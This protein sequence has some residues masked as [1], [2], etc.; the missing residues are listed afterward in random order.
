MGPRRLE[1][2]RALIGVRVEASPPAVGALVPPR[3]TGARLRL[4]SNG[5]WL[6][7]A[8]LDTLPT[9]TEQSFPAQCASALMAEMLIEGDAAE[10]RTGVLIPG[11][12]NGRRIGLRFTRQPCQL[13]VAIGNEPPFFSADAPLP[14]AGLVVAGLARAINRYLSDHPS[15][16]VVPLNIATANTHPLRII[17]F[18]AELEAPP[19]AATPD[20][21]PPEPT[22]QPR[23][24]ERALLPPT[25]R[26]PRV[27]RL[28]DA[29]HAPGSASHLCHRGAPVQR[30]TAATQSRRR[31]G[32]GHT[33]SPRR[34]T[35]L[36]GRHRPGLLAHRPPGRRHPPVGLQPPARPPA[37]GR[38][39]LVAGMPR[40]T[41]QPA[42]VC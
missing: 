41:R 2:A 4:F 39:A 18:E 28:C 27:A 13:S 12:L 30:P 16:A 11:M 6:P 1:S 23:P 19:P 31:R 40:R 29:D 5:S 21:P 8:P 10:K 3:R 37:A 17:A 33:E 32:P 42:V 9:G 34:R 7:L 20:A 25:D 38:P 15:A 24:G 22:D 14:E 35:R 36:P 26:I